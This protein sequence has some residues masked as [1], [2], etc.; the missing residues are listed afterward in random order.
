MISC[1]KRKPWVE[2]PMKRKTAKELSLACYWLD[3]KE[4]ALFD[5]PMGIQ[6]AF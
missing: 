3:K 1:K 6:Q 2:Q 4:V 5:S